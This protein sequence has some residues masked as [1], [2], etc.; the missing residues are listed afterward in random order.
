[1][2][3]NRNK[4]NTYMKCVCIK[5]NTYSQKN[6]IF[7]Y[8]IVERTFGGHNYI[9]TIKEGKEWQVL[10]ENYFIKNFVNQQFIRKK[11]LERLWL[12]RKYKLNQRV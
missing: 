3:N 5:N 1:M 4:L 11:K 12:K 10:D 8:Q 2:V 7:E 6:E 9:I